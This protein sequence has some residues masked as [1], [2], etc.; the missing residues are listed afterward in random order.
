MVSR[1]LVFSC[2]LTLCRNLSIHYEFISHRGLDQMRT[3]RKIRDKRKNK[4]VSISSQA[5][6]VFDCLFIVI[7]LIII[8]LY[9]D[10]SALE[11]LPI[12]T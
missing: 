4:I 9:H 6:W 1:C 8:L 3:K 11:G 7:K 5:L 12:M 10:N 2:M